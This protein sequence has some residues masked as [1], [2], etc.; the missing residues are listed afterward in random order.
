ME[1]V[2][3]ENSTFSGGRKLIL[4]E[5]PLIQVTK[6]KDAAIFVLNNGA[7]A[8][9]CFHASCSNHTWQDVRKEV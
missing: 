8:F 7:I 2:V 4:E 1:L 3:K 9:K 6:G 5:C